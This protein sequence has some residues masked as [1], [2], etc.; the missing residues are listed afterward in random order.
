MDIKISKEES[1]FLNKIAND[2]LF[3]YKQLFSC[4]IH[5]TKIY[6]LSIIDIIDI[7]KTPKLFIKKIK[8]SNIY[9]LY[10]RKNE[11][12]F[13]LNFHKK[14]LQSIQTYCIKTIFQYNLIDKKETINKNNNLKMD[15]EISKLLS[16]N[17]K[18]IKI[19]KCFRGYILRL[20]QLPLIMYKI[21]KY[22]ELQVFKCSNKYKDGRINS[23]IDE[24]NII[25]LLIEKFNKKIKKP[26]IR[27]WY[28]ILAYDYI[29]GWIPINIKTTT[30]QT[31]DNTGNLAMCVYAYTDEVLN[32][33]K[34]YDNGKMSIILFNKLK[35]KKYNKFN[36]KDYYFIVLNKKNLN[37]IIINSVKGLTI[38]TPNINNLPFQVCWN[39]NRIFKYEHIN[40]KI[41]QFIECLKKPKQSWKE[42][43]MSN[44]RTI[45]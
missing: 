36:K 28:D 4:L 17:T 22:L 19:Q 43:F 40:K 3:D 7:K 9:E 21:K 15:L 38:L 11:T 2:F 16:I 30:T 20:K 45:E 5:V 29:Y 24:D 8:N 44:V 14:H 26:K 25:K 42:I 34:S 10:I 37:D 35:N 23:C 32:L 13:K 18:V 39:K 12:E 41:N 27:M 1:L 6:N 33:D 31:S